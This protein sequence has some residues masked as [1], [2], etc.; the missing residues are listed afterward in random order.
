MPARMEGI[1]AV[2]GKNQWWYDNHEVHSLVTTGP[3]IGHNPDQFIVEFEIDV[4]AKASGE[5]SQMKEVGLYTAKD[6]KVVQEE[7]LYLMG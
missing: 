2:K 5:R 6:G 3:F 4:T 7:F 1:E